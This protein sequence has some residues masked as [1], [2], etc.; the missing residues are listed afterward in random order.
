ME[1]LQSALAFAM[2]IALPHWLLRW[3][4]RRL[5]Q[6]QRDRGF[7]DASHWAAIV[8]FSVVAIP[9]HFCKTRRTFLALVQ[10]LAWAALTLLVISAVLSGVEFVAEL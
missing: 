7:N 10:G 8:G 1:V 3:D 4:D 6:E 2:G 9:V 5:T